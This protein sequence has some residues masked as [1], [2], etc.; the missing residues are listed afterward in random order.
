MGMRK[1]H[2]NHSKQIIKPDQK[3]RNNTVNI[4]SDHGNVLNRFIGL[5]NPV[6]K[7][8]M[9]THRQRVDKYYKK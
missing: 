5:T 7:S 6:Q 2:P 1:H 8:T 4:E 3:K 9:V